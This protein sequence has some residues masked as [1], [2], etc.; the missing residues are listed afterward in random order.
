MSKRTLS[1]MKTGFTCDQYL[2]EETR[3]NLTEMW[4]VFVVL[5]LQVFEK[6]PLEFVDVLYVTEDCLQLWLSEHVRVFTALTDVTL[7]T[8]ITTVQTLTNRW[9][10]IIQS[11]HEHKFKIIFLLYQECMSG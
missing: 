3:A 7:K 5:L 1:D 4:L 6:L 11:V 9:R 10:W 2:Q 8:R